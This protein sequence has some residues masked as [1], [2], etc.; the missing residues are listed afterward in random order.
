MRFDSELIYHPCSSGRNPFPKGI[1]KQ[2]NGG[3]AS[4]VTRSNHLQFKKPQCSYG[5][6]QTCTAG[7]EQVK[8]TD[9]GSD[10]KT[11]VQTSNMVQ[12]IHQPRMGAADTNDKPIVLPDPKGKI[13]VNRIGASCL[14]I[15]VER[16]AGVS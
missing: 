8:T 5:L 10:P 2:S 9:D 15:E 12:G 7:V 13:I 14:W 4:A 11:I 6:V 1:T 3:F 16:T